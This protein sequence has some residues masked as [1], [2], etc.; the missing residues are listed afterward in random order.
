MAKT[1][2]GISGSLIAPGVVPQVAQEEQALATKIMAFVGGAAAVAGGAAQFAAVQEEVQAMRDTDKAL[3]AQARGAGIPEQF[4]TFGVHNAIW[5]N[6][7]NKALDT[8]DPA[9]VRRGP[10]EDDTAV[11]HRL[12]GEHTPIGAPT[13][14]RATFNEGI[15]Q[16]FGQ[17][18][19]QQARLAQR[20]AIE[21]VG[22]DVTNQ[23]VNSEIV[24]LA[25][26]NAP[27]EILIDGVGGSETDKLFGM[28]RAAQIAAAK[29]DVDRT[30]LISEWIGSVKKRPELVIG[31]PEKATKIFQKGN[32]IVM[33]ENQQLDYGVGET[34][35]KTNE[36]AI[37]HAVAL[38]KI[39]KTQATKL[40]DDFDKLKSDTFDDWF[41]TKLLDRTYSPKQAESDI[42]NV[43][44]KDKWIDPSKGVRNL[45]LYGEHRAFF[46]GMADVEKAGVGDNTVLTKAHNNP[47]L[48]SMLNDGTVILGEVRPGSTTRSFHSFIDGRRNEAF[49]YM[50]AKFFVPSQITSNI[51]VGG[52]S[53][54][55]A[56]AQTAMLNSVYLLRKNP[57]AW[58]RMAQKAD[59]NAR[60]RFWNIAIADSQS[61]FPTADEPRT[62][63]RVAALM[64]SL[65]TLQPF[66]PKHENEAFNI[67]WGV[68][69]EPVTRRSVPAKFGRTVRTAEEDLNKMLPFELTR[70]VTEIKF[71][72]FAIPRVFNRDITNYA[73]QQ[74][75][76]DYI[77]YA[78]SATTAY[79]ASNVPMLEAAEMGKLWARNQVYLENPP[80]VDGNDEVVAVPGMPPDYS[81]IADLGQNIYAAALRNPEVEKDIAQTHRII[82]VNDENA[83]FG[84][85]SNENNETLT[86]IRKG[87]PVP[88]RYRPKRGAKSSESPQET[89]DSARKAAAIPAPAVP[90]DPILAD[91]E[92]QIYIDAARAGHIPSQ[93]A[94]DE[95]SVEWRQNP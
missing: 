54:N 26:I 17:F 91:P 7:A 41:S 73:T 24:R 63:A 5:R 30:E 48:Q 45:R 58:G 89:I 49:D 31:L 81:Q 16:K 35:T 32:F 28:V 43:G 60:A 72:P 67:T 69:D 37:T 19:V 39:S 29:G 53:E 55:R 2:L 56:V 11:I 34:P 1:R 76:T 77:Q 4:E 15:R 78:Q 90:I 71:G 36:N 82:W 47:M 3:D 93:E 80:I 66:E 75:I 52:A 20:K 87:N 85:V 27:Y 92:T 21:D 83:G 6:E 68:S 84:L 8:I 12:I 50:A 79:M 61:P 86:F 62:A 14:F 51:R 9:T 22:D 23:A 38:G 13:I 33:Q 70:G 74:M 95:L 59:P 88:F 18:I 46:A 64:D 44:I 94:L 65:M 25:E 10:N 57:K 42:L 40:N